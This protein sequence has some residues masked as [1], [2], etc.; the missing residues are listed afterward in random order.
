MGKETLISSAIG[1]IVAYCSDVN[2]GV[3]FANGNNYIFRRKD[4]LALVP[5]NNMQVTFRPSSHNAFDIQAL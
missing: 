5:A 4:C 2:A 1:K 3:I